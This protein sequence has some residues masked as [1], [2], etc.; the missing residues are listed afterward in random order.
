MKLT[1]QAVEA[2]QPGQFLWDRNLGVKATSTGA[3][4]FVLGYHAG[5]R[6]RRFTIGE[7]DRPWSV[8]TA[9]KEAQRLLG[10]I[11]TGVDPLAQSKRGR[12]VPTLREVL[13]RV[14]REH[15]PKRKPT[16]AREYRRIFDAHLGPALGSRA[17]TEISRADVAKLHHRLAS[18]P[19]QANFAVAILSKVMN[20]AEAWDYRPLNSNPC[21]IEKFREVRRERFLDVDELGRLGTVLAD[22]ERAGAT[23]PHAIAAI[24]V[25][26]L[27]GARVSEIVT[28][29]WDMVDLDRG[30]ARLSDSKT[31]AKTIHLS[32]PAVAVLAGLVREV[33][34]PHVFIGRRPGAHL[35]DLRG[36]WGRVRAEADLKGVRL[37]D[38][39]HSFASVG[40]SGGLSLPIVGRLLGHAT[41]AMTSRYAHLAADPVHAAA[42][43]IGATLQAALDPRPAPAGSVK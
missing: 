36:V 13:D 40:V 1:R 30:V 37:H 41:P 43:Q 26:L 6:R 10:L 12:A 9:E 19:R 42:A 22:L 28:L 18:T 17:I 21:R 34:N 32:P 29:T 3:K 11:A 38:L 23:S 31:G 35:G 15:L 8:A 14:E 20:L 5:R 25:L 4:I 33:G 27:T 2:L 39:R 16:T 7:F 24:R